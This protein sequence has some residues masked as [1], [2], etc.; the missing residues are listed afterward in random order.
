MTVVQFR[1][2]F[3]AEFGSVKISCLAG[4]TTL[5]LKFVVDRD[6]LPWPNSAELAVWNLNA[7]N[8]AKLTAGG[9]VAAK[10]QAGYQ[11]NV[12]QIFYGLLDIVEHE[13]DT[14]TGDWITRMSASDCGE[15]I[16]QARVTASFNKG[17]TVLSVLK[18]ILKP[19]GLGEGNLSS[20]T[21]DPALLRT[22]PHGGSL[23]GNAAEELAYFLRS[24][25]LEFS[26]QDGKLQFCKIGEGAPN[27]EGPL[28]SANTGM[29]NA[30]KLSREKQTDLT[31]KGKAKTPN[32]ITT[33]FGE[34]V[35]LV[36]TVEATCL[37]QPALVPGVPF[38]IES[39]NVNGD[40]L[41][42]ATRHSGDTHE[43]DWYTQVKGVPL[44]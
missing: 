2:A 35:D 9:A 1:R 33:V 34:Q 39:E 31:K 14:N 36:T 16:K 4:E 17:A 5:R 8:R 25:G 7:D 32:T 42:V 27:T 13:K 22:L 30:P 29:V 23:H 15:K 3:E 43:Q 6:K 18:T 10:I 37:L 19:L 21:L 11:G 26:I 40:F 44:K 41:A 20:F 28:L 24:A 12:K 38:R